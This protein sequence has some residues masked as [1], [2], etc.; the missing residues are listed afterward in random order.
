MALERGEQMKTNGNWTTEL[1]IVLEILVVHALWC[2]L[3]ICV[4][5][6]L[7]HC[8][9][10][11]GSVA[12]EIE[13]EKRIHDNHNSGLDAGVSDIGVT[14]DTGVNAD[15]GSIGVTDADVSDN[16]ADE[17]ADMDIWCT[18]GDDL[19]LWDWDLEDAEICMMRE[20]DEDRTRCMFHWGISWNC[21]AEVLQYMHCIENCKLT[22]PAGSVDFWL[23]EAVY[24]RLGCGD[25]LNMQGASWGLRML[26]C[27]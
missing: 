15:A 19:R 26:Q 25:K 7:V 4:A 18:P 27:D 23:E 10:A 12:D 22:A 13:I 17:T 8:D 3:I 11:V 2:A 1:L 9:H 21:A 16:D 24:C 20:G 6:L 14:D 5:G